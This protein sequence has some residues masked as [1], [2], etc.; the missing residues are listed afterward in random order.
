MYRAPVQEIAFT[1][2]K[3]ADLGKVVADPRHE[4]VGEDLVAAILEE[5]GRFAGEQIAPLN[6]V[7]DRI[8]AKWENGEVTM[9]PGWR[10]A[11]RAW[12]EG[13]WNS[14]TADPEFGGQGL[15]MMLQAA[16][17]EMWNSGSMAFAIG[18]TLTVGAIEALEKH[19]SDDLKTTYLPKLVSGEWMGTMNLTE[20][21]AGSDLN[22]LR[23]RAERAEDGTYRIF[24]QKIYITYGEHDF[25]DNIVHLVLARL[26]DAPAGTR[27]ISL[28]VVPKFLVN[29]DGSLGARNDARC[30]GIEHKLGIHAS[31]T[32]TMVYGDEGGAIGWLVGE[33]NRGLACMF[34]MMN[35]ARLAVGI[36]GLGVAERATQQAVAYALERRQ[37]RSADHVGEG[38]SPIA[39]HPDIRRTLLDMQAWTQVSRAICYACAQAIDL[40][41]LGED[42]EAR[43]HWGE[44]AAMLTPIAK[45]LSTDIG[46]EVA[47]LGVQ[48]H[49]GMGYVEETGAARHLRDARI[50]PIYEGTNGIQ[51]IDLVMRKLPLSGGEHLAGFIGE[52]S[53]IAAAARNDSAADLADAGTRL[54]QALAQLAEAG[55]WMLDAQADGRQQEALA[56]ATPFLR[57]MGIALGGALLVKGAL[58]CRDDN[59]APARNRRLWATYFAA[60]HLPETAALRAQVEGLAASVLAF[61]PAA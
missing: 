23:A 13:G 11:Y 45:A 22:A 6:E 40:S 29:E 57:L 21:Q 3:V 55:R 7:G 16:A 51:A 58:A 50:A 14:L 32:C 33:E 27:G 15:P 39:L 48:V 4:E 34:T 61:E 20:P 5:A 31:P 30:A 25:T 60:A 41:G 9:P 26:P 8:G 28:F 19:A 52:L 56:G 35:N 12:A 10:D 2:N 43:K 38:M 42:G 37:G 1:L 59:S 36:Q 17:L 53:E 54:E 47:S 44:R 24:G 46:V 49:G 18:P